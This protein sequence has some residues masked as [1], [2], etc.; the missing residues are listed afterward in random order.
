LLSVFVQLTLQLKLSNENGVVSYT[1][2]QAR[3]CE[4][5]TVGAAAAA[6]GR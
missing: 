6:L 1:A 2:V 5:A 4:L 3:R